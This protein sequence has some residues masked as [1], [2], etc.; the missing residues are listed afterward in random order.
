[1]GTLNNRKQYFN[2]GAI[3]IGNNSY[4]IEKHHLLK[5]YLKMSATEII[6]FIHFLPL[7][8][9]NLIPNNDTWLFCLNFIEIINILKSHQL[10]PDLIS[11]LK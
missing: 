10:T 6:S 9:G 7:M 2:Y 3:K 5:F 4:T 11:C 8:I 1:M